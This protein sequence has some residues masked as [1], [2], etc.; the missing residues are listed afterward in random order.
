M[1]RK[2]L[3]RICLGLLVATSAL[4]L[5]GCEDDEKDCVASAC[6]DPG[7]ITR[8]YGT[9]TATA[10]IT[11][12]GQTQREDVTMT[13][14]GDAARMSEED[15]FYIPQTGGRGAYT[16]AR[17]DGKDRQRRFRFIIICG[18]RLS[19]D[20]YTTHSGGGLSIAQGSLDFAADFNSCELNANINDHKD[21][22]MTMTA[23]FTR[24]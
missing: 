22:L 4:V 12:G 19:M 6:E 21:G 7:D 18:R 3:L 23:T 5:V 13:F 17:Q 14:G 8:F 15:Y 16:F 1:N 10:T 24:T 20:E 9:F 2:T 11:A